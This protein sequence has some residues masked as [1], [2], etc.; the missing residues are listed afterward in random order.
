M[1]EQTPPPVSGQEGIGTTV[2]RGLALVLVA[3][4]VLG[5]LA[6]LQPF[7]TAILFGSILAI[8]LWPLRVMLVARGFRTGRAATLLLLLVIAAIILPLLAVAPGL[9]S[10]I[11]GGSTTLRAMVAAAPATP[12]AW[13][14]ELPM[15]GGWIVAKWTHLATTHGEIGP[16]IAPYAGRIQSVLISVATGLADSTLQMLLALVVATMIWSSGEVIG[17]A[18]MHGAVRL[19]GPTGAAALEAAAGAVR[20][21]AYGVVGTSVLQGVLAGIGFAIAG[22]PAAALLGFLTLVFSISQV[23]GPLVVVTWAG[24]A[25]W[26]YDGGSTGW[27][28]FMALWGALA[29]SSGDNVLRPL[30]IKRGVEMPL[31]LI[32]LGVFGG[33]V[34]F[35]FL[36]LFIGPTMLAVGL[37]MLRA[38]QANTRRA[39]VL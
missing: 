29:V 39:T 2:E 10:A 15:V 37:V 27:A 7:A 1:D 33:F 25:W 36:G 19:G 16:L 21:V 20:S 34:A 38:W 23:L 17:E 6:T 22:V 24:A 31:S 30:L 26:L 32:I 9:V 4:V 5:V 13:L 8:A 18:M 28:I 3:A 14:A 12:P 35:G 11:E